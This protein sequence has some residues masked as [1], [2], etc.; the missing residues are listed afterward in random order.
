MATAATLRHL[1]D[2]E[3][4]DEHASATKELFNLRFQI[5]T[6]QSE[7][8]SQLGALRRDI[9]RMKTVL[10]ER[11]IAAADAVADVDAVAEPPTDATDATDGESK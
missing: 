3:L 5:A 7:N 10:R 1:S 11:E 6:S 2:D 9:A 8:S 4:L